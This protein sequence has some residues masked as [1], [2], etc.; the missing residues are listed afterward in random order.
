MIRHMDITPHRY[1]HYTSGVNGDYSTVTQ[2]SQSGRHRQSDGV[3]MLAGEDSNS[4]GFTITNLLSS[5]RDGESG[6]GS[7]NSVTRNC[8]D[9]VSTSSNGITAVD[10]RSD[11]E[12]SPSHSLTY[13][14]SPT[15]TDGTSYFINKVPVPNITLLNSSSPAAYSGQFASV[16]SS[17]TNGNQQSCFVQA[18]TQSYEGSSSPPNNM[19]KGKAC[20]YLCNRDLWLKFHQHNTEMIITKQGRRMFPTLSFRFSGIDPNAHYNVFVD[21]V[22]A[23][24]NHWKFQS[25]KWVPCGQ[26]E[27][28][29]P[30]SNIYIHPDSPNTGTH[31]MKQEVVFSKLKLTNNKGKDNGHIVLNSMHK[32]QPRI[33][34]IEVS[35]NRPPD[36]R[37]LQTHSFPETQF[38]A[39]TAYQNTDIT[40][41][42]IDHN[43][44]AKGFRDNYDSF[45]RTVER[46][47]P[48][49]SSSS[50]HNGSHTIRSTRPAGG[51]YPVGPPI[52]A[53]SFKAIHPG[54]TI[55]ASTPQ[56]TVSPKPKT[57][58]VSQDPIK[59]ENFPP[60]TVAPHSYDMNQIQQQIR[61]SY[62]VST[63]LLTT[64]QPYLTPSTTYTTTT[65][66]QRNSYGLTSSPNENDQDDIG[67]TAPPSNSSSDSGIYE[68][69][70]KRQKLSPD[71]SPSQEN[72]TSDKDSNV[73]SKSDDT[74]VSNEYPGNRHHV[75]YYGY[76][77]TYY[78]GA[79]AYPTQ[80]YPHYNEYQSV[81][82]GEVHYGNYP[83]L[84]GYSGGY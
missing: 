57:G 61:D 19:F 29:H 51:P 62:G 50:L 70:A 82:G 10:S 58:D 9:S 53:A 17:Y 37:T 15:S 44:F 71:N 35:P 55:T 46:F 12:L 30:G 6:G 40:Q 31:W 84:P 69:S 74:K 73:A 3:N 64:T 23:D 45:N 68:Q 33:H 78:G 59:Y 25:G 5:Y 39:V 43:P 77:H 34:V 67:C 24:P 22:L 4:D 56:S 38:F 52:P 65:A 1:S 79:E 66:S 18:T 7:S 76:P 14:S 72:T 48:P 42:K 63:L 80:A 16:D 26:A 83:S 36:Q 49:P 8:E 11:G 21:M 41:L 60:N 20:V 75:N 27:H 2:H 47:T 81:T 13:R 32:Y 54:P 28:V